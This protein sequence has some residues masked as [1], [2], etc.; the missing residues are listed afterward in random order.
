MKRLQ[1]KHLIP[2]RKKGKIDKRDKEDSVSLLQEVSDVYSLHRFH[3]RPKES[4]NSLTCF[5][6]R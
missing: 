5:V 2:I 3:F 4:F 6:K 1:R